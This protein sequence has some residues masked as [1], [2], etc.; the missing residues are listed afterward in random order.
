MVGPR[1]A[2]NLLFDDVNVPKGH[3]Y[4]PRI[5]RSVPPLWLSETTDLT[6]GITTPC[7]GVGEI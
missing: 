5:Y 7:L 3:I 4:Q 1:P 6:A 2:A